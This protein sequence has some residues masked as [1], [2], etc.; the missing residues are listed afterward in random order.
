MPPVLIPNSFFR[1]CAATAKNLSPP[2]SGR[3]TLKGTQR[4]P[5]MHKSF[6]Q[7][8]ISWG[9]GKKIM[10]EEAR[11]TAA[12]YLMSGIDL[13]H[14]LASDG[15]ART[16]IVARIERLVR[17]ERLKGAHRHWSYDLNRHIALKQALDRLRSPAGG[18]T[19][20]DSP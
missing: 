19:G 2:L 17:R 5:T 16:R 14:A 6:S 13:S 18:M 11:Q 7:D 20:R 4:G 12:F 1:L 15:D 10:E 9:A 3:L 8:A